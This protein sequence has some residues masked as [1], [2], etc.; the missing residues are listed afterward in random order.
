M[1]DKITYE[2]LL[3]KLV[4]EY[5][6]SEEAANKFIFD[7][8]KDEN[9]KRKANEALN[10]QNKAEETIPVS[11]TIV[12]KNITK[13]EPEKQKPI[14]EDVVSKPN[15]PRVK[16]TLDNMPKKKK[17]FKLIQKVAAVVMTI[18]LVSLALMSPGIVEKLGEYQANENLNNEVASL[19]VTDDA[20][21][22]GNIN[23]LSDVQKF[24]DVDFETL[25]QI[26]PDTVGWLEWEGTNIDYPVVQGEDNDY[27]LHHA[28][29]GK[30]NSA[31]TLFMDKDNSASFTDDVTVIF[32][33]NM[34]NDSMFGS[35]SNLQDQKFYEEH[36][37]MYYHT[38]DAVYEIDLFSAVNQDFKDLT[39]GNYNDS[40]EFVTDMNEVKQN[41]TFQS[42]VQVDENSQVVVLSTCLDSG[43]NG[44]D[45]RF[46][47]YGSVNKVLDK[48]MINNMTAG[49]QR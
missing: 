35:L 47:V 6:W 1:S 13:S 14:I 42:D 46:L 8:V 41:S 26:N 31:G 17:K 22:V 19:V 10:K 45:N 32:G 27:Y 3:S 2:Q 20:Y 25:K 33:H 29:D 36:P 44:T 43:S 38:E 18:S 4:D 11:E 16:I 7:S 39:Y 15:R 34:R 23:N 24:N 28:I 21:S 49:R 30:E 37:T 40:S 9:I 12:E 48:T 5:G